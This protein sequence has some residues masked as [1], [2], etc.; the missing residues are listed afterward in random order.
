MV[1]GL[2]VRARKGSKAE[3]GGLSLDKGKTAFSLRQEGW[4]K[5]LGWLDKNAAGRE[6]IE[7]VLD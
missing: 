6:E 5:G 1:Q 3:V 7:R 4:R 2:K